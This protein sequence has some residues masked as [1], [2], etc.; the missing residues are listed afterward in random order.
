LIPIAT[1]ISAVVFLDAAGTY[2]QNYIEYLIASLANEFQKDYELE[3]I[4]NPEE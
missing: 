1:L 3:E 2:K 4:Q